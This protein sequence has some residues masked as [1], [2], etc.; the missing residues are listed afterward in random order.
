MKMFFNYIFTSLLSVSKYVCVCVCVHKYDYC[1]LQKGIGLKKSE[2]YSI[3]FMCTMKSLILILVRLR[4]IY[5]YNLIQS[6]C[7]SFLSLRQLLNQLQ[8]MPLIP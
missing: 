3:S 2:T 1:Q 7:T 4:M 8:A 6:Y 5:P